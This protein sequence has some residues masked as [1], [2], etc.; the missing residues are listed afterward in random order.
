MCFKSIYIRY[1]SK[2]HLP[3]SIYVKHDLTY[4]SERE[5]YIYIFYL[6]ITKYG[7][8]DLGASE[9]NRNLFNLLANVSHVENINKQLP[10]I[11]PARG[12]LPDLLTSTSY[13]DYR[14]EKFK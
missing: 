3:V 12:Q 6:D 9:L 10:S 5:L 7:T 2:L 11:I 8:T 4:L 13:V 14:I 1:S